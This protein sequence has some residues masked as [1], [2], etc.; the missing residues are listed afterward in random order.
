MRTFSKGASGGSSPRRKAK[1]TDSL[2]TYIHTY[3]HTFLTNGC[4]IG[5]DLE[6]YIQTYP[7]ENYELVRGH[8]AFNKFGKRRS[9]WILLTT[10]FIM[11]RRY[12]YRS[13]H[14]K[15]ANACMYYVCINIYMHLCC[16]RN[17]LKKV[18]L[19]KAVI[20]VCMKNPR[21]DE[22]YG[23]FNRWDNPLAYTP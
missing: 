23:L 2:Y 13:I 22:E 20:R 14:S 16:A 17:T 11:P 5:G 6:N 3:I 18:G 15:L 4:D 10:S 8:I 19:L 12:I 9:L 1:V 7:F 21:Y